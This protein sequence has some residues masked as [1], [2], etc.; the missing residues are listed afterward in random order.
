MKHSGA[1]GRRKYQPLQC[2]DMGSTIREIEAR[3]RTLDQIAA[4]VKTLAGELA[5]IERDLGHIVPKKRMRM[6]AGI[7]T[8]ELRAVNGI[9]RLRRSL[10]R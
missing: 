4:R 2:P 8:G 3:S 1:S 7:A 10:R 9:V 5:S 6:I